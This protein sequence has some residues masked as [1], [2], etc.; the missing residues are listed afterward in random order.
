[1]NSHPE[2]AT[3]EV[4]I[5]R[6]TFPILDQT[7]NGKPLIYLDNGATTQ[8]PNSVIQAMHNYY[9][10]QNSNVHRGV[11]T[12]S[13]DLTIA[14]EKVR[15]DVQ[16][17]MKVEQVHE[18]IFTSGTTEGIN[19]VAHGLSQCHFKAGDEIMLSTMEHHS[20]I[21]PWQQCALA[22]GLKIIEIP[23]SEKG[24]LRME[25][26]QQRLSSKTALIAISHV[27]NTLGTI[28]PVKEICRIAKTKNIP[29]L[30]DGAQAIAHL[31]VNVK[32]IG[33]DFYVFSAHKMYGPTGM[34]VAYIQEKWLN[35]FP[36]Y[37]TGGGTIKSVSL[38]HT[39]FADLPL[40]MEAGT[41][42]ME[43]IIGLGAA[44]QW[45]K[46]NDIS[47]IAKHEH[48]LLQVAT[49]AL[50]QIPGIS[51]YGQSENK[52]AVL[53]FNVKGLHP[54]DIGM[55]LDKLGIAIRTG[56]HCTQPLWQFYG[57]EGCCR[58]SFAAYNTEEEVN[59]LISGLKKAI[60]ML[61]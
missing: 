14:C 56:H 40:K 32:E 27:S 39:I 42:H 58:A 33:C 24:E 25:A 60:Q 9:C 3:L 57:I 6:K 31:P 55:I 16:A 4:E 37:K 41:P 30:V 59:Q 22:L 38:E 28:N 44:I 36:P 5:V 45:L 17:F 52:A 20:N 61:A 48:H 51:L 10:K 1:M 53:S 34:G 2:T 13:R 46:E 49:E 23:I 35:R 43:G 18:I 12:L 11:H 21:V 7:V 47:A 8:K 26:F 54:F 15:E 19:M 29:V 50:L